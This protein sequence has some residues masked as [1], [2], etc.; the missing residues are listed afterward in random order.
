M[1][2]VQ[3]MAAGLCK[4]V[5]CAG[6]GQS[7][8]LVE[9]SAC[10]TDGRGDHIAALCLF[11]F[12]YAVLDVH[13]GVADD[14][15]GDGSGLQGH[16]VLQVPHAQQGHEGD[17]DVGADAWGG[18]VVDGAHLEVVF[19]HPEGVLHLPQAAVLAQDG[20]VAGGLRQV[21][22]DPVQGRPSVAPRLSCP[23]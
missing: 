9:L 15:R 14:L 18:P 12:Q 21:G 19:A 10:L 16:S 2:G 8:H 17:G 6:V 13:Q 11:V 7:H 3:G 22:D 4:F 1:P 23:G 20:G 5:R